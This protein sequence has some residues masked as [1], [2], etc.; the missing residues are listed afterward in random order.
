MFDGLKYS[1]I[2]TEF[3]LQINGKQPV[4]G[5]RH[6]C[7]LRWAVAVSK[8][9]ENDY[10]R[11]LKVVPRLK[12]EQEV[13]EICRDALAYVKR[14]PSPYLS[15]ELRKAIEEVRIRQYVESRNDE[16]DEVMQEAAEPDIP[17][18]L[19]PVIKELVDIC[20]ND[21][22]PMMLVTAMTMI[23]EYLCRYRAQYDTYEWEFPGFFQVIEAE[24]GGGKSFVDIAHDLLLKKAKDHDDVQGEMLENYRIEKERHKNDTKYVA[25]PPPVPIYMLGP[26]KISPSELLL[27]AKSNQGVALL[28]V[29]AEIDSHTNANKGNR[30]K[31]DMERIGFD[32]GL[33]SQRY[34][35]NDTVYGSADL[36]FSFILTGTPNAVDRAYAD[37]ENGLVTRYIFDYLDTEY[38]PKAVF[39]KL[40]KKSLNMIERTMD[41]AMA[42]VFDED[43][44]VQPIKTMNLS[45][46]LP[47]VKAQ[48]E[49]YQIL[50]AS[51]KDK[52][53]DRFR[54]RAPKIGFRGMMVANWLWKNK[55]E[56]RQDVIDFGLWLSD[57]VLD[58]QMRRMGDAYKA[59]KKVRVVNVN[60]GYKQCLM[61]ALYDALP[62]EF[63][64]ELV[65]EKKTEMGI[66]SVTKQCILLMKKYGIAKIGKNLYKKQL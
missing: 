26:T 3:F 30:D 53:L 38:K 6:N 42:E 55:K 11:L 22:K 36:Y 47:A 2:A 63:G 56:H 45:W 9:C 10:Q 43:G 19:P 61:R 49:R 8:I 34:A 54:R 17:K 28:S 7:L 35:G 46:A 5:E 60:N 57:R 13:E 64:K 37:S 15:R 52:V 27:E 25:P 66:G 14:N 24:A 58:T 33:Y 16:V 65:E 32:G 18:V 29:C 23:G 62:E 40:S 12:P 50:A 31:S 21:Y 20:P 4:E 39:E 41:R 59:Q 1:D 48:I 51:Q 44:N